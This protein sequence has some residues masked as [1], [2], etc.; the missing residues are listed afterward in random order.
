[1]NTVTTTR[2]RGFTL[3]ELMITV[4]I[5]A[6]LASIAY[7]SYVQYVHRANRA[8]AKTAI[9]QDVQFLERNFTVANS[10]AQDSAGNA[11]ALPI[12]QSPQNGSGAY[13]ISLNPAPTAT[14]YT[15]EAAPVTGGSMDGDDCGTLSIDQ[16]GTKGASGTLSVS[17]CWNR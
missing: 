3:I 1:M 11:I 6:I 14:T 2:Q 12:T 13:T 10:Y 5:V 9:L 16:T 17:T 15:I 7:P 4:A 8:E